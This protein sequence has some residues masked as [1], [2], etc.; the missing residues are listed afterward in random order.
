MAP[1]R[2]WRALYELREHGVELVSSARVLRIDERALT[3]QREGEQARSVPA[4][5][6]ILATGVR[7]DTRLAD[8]L[9]AQGREV[10]VVGDCGGV[11]YI[12]GAIRDAHRVAAAL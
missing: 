2:R 4:D 3:L 11:G 10:H 9:R 6:V 1:P 7:G 8:A 12:E 5:A